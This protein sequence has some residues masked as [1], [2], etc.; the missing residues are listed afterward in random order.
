MLNTVVI[1][2][3]PVMKYVGFIIFEHENPT[4]VTAANKKKR[5][6]SMTGS[7][8][9]DFCDNLSCSILSANKNNTN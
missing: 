9:F 4:P 5:D 1:M 7:F 2:D 8:K 3:F 6:L